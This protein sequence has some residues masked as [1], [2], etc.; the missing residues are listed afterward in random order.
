MNY[1][2]RLNGPL[3]SGLFSVLL[4]HKIRDKKFRLTFT[5]GKP[6]SL[7]PLIHPAVMQS[8]LPSSMFFEV[9]SKPEI[10]NGFYRKIYYLTK[11]FRVKL[12]LKTDIAR[13]GKRFVRYRFSRAI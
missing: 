10:S 4:S 8:K 12:H 5:F 3:V 13:I 7:V 11:E 6:L 9:R 2:D 1:H